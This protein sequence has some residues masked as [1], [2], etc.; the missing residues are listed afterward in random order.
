MAGYGF[1]QNLRG[2]GEIGGVFF[3]MGRGLGGILAGY[4]NYWRPNLPKSL[5]GLFLI[6]VKISSEYHVVFGISRV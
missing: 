4:L 1:Y 2:T 3:K 6:S 5:V